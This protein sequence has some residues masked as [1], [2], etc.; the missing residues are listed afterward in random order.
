MKI[1]N[2]GNERQLQTTA[3]TVG[4]RTRSLQEIKDDQKNQ[5]KQ[6]GAIYSGELRWWGLGQDKVEEER[7]KAK[8]IAQYLVDKVKVKDQAELTEIDEQNAHAEELRALAKETDERIG[9]AKRDLAELED[10]DPDDK[11][12]AEKKK[13]LEGAL[14]DL[15]EEKARQED[16]MR[17]AYAVARGMKLERLKHHDMLDAQEQG[18]EILEAAE[19]NVIGILTEEVKNK[20]DQDMEET[21]EKAEEKKE[22]EELLEERIEAAKERRE[23]KDDRI[24]KDTKDLV[25]LQQE[26]EEIRKQQENSNL[27]DM[28]KSLEL[29]V[30]ELQLAAE[31][32]KGLLVDKEL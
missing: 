28:K 2:N 22:E 29:V 25:E 13:M 27:P 32:V 1:V 9:A 24:E 21:K 8:E 12:A 5:K 7:R 14:A 3:D 31:D 15:Q 23:E 10:V 26:Q 30:G 6:S 17:A 19:K 16:D 18:E 4:G 11:D 20:V